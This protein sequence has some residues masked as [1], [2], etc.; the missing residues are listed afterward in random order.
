VNLIPSSYPPYTLPH[1]LMVHRFKAESYSLIPY[2]V[3]VAR[4]EDLSLS[5]SKGIIGYEGIR[6]QVGSL[7]F[8]HTL[9]IPSGYTGMRSR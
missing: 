5:L 6:C 7:Y 9:L 2:C 1:T 8:P 3:W 4:L